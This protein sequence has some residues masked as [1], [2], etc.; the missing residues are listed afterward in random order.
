[1][2]RFLLTLAF[3][4]SAAPALAAI[5]PVT[6]NDAG[7]YNAAATTSITWAFN[8]VGGGCANCAMLVQVLGDQTT[9]DLQ[10]ATYN[11]TAM[12]FLDKTNAGWRWTYTFGML[13]PPS[14]SNDIVVTASSI[15]QL[16]GIA[17]SYSGVGSFGAHAGGLGG[18]GLNVTGTLTTLAANSWVYLGGVAPD[19]TTWAGVTNATIRNYFVTTS[20]PAL[21]DNNAAVAVQAYSMTVTTG[22]TT[23]LAIVM[24]E[25]EDAGGGGG[26][27]TA[28]RTL[29]LGVGVPE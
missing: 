3:V 22:Q 27:A 5:A 9:D 8:A 24:V 19:V 21:F 1:M 13:A 4:L 12:T 23:D 18:N 26:G 17:I 15:H 7:T 16:A 29:T 11:G 14:G 20:G 2:K 6:T 28:K 25:L 10:G